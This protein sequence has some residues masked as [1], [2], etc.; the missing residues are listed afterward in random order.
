MCRNGLFSYVILFTMSGLAGAAGA[1][2][3]S[4]AA[5]VSTGSVSVEGFDD[6]MSARSLDV[7]FDADFGNGFVLGGDIGVQNLDVGGF[8][9]NID[10]TVLS[11]DGHYRFANGLTVGAYAQRIEID[12]PF[13]DR[14]F[15][16]QGATLGYQARRWGI[17]AFYGRTDFGDMDIEA[18]D[19]GLIAYA[20]PNDRLTLG[21]SVVH[22][23]IDV[24]D[25]DPTLVRLAGVY[26]LSDTV[27]VFAG[28]DALS[29]DEENIYTVGLGLG[30]DL[31][32][33][34][35]FPAVLSVEFTHQSVDEM[36]IDGVE[37]ALTIPLGRVASKAPLG[38]VAGHVLR[39]KRS[40]LNGLYDA[41]VPL[42]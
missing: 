2:E 37:L 27:T 29:F 11:I 12:Q 16:S 38:S 32:R 14:A 5:S 15:S 13:R 1:Q 8:I 26:D 24:S 40:A 7:G 35:G 39:P 6:D 28:V 18:K 23:D 30:Y 22:S 36:K 42:F 4:G 9:G 20:L 31:T 17:E 19:Y 41:G 25:R 34:T 33:V 10:T 21:A 3:F